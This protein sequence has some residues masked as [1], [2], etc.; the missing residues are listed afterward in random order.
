M[1]GEPFDSACRRELIYERF[2]RSVVGCTRA[3]QL[4]PKAV[5]DS[6]IDWSQLQHA[7]GAATDLP[8]LLRACTGSDLDACLAARTELRD[9]VFHQ[10]S[11]YSSTGPALRVL[12]EGLDAK[13]ADPSVACM[14]FLFDVL[15]HL[16]PAFAAGEKRAT[17]N[18]RA[19]REAIEGAVPKLQS[20]ST[21]ED[22][23]VKAWAVHLLCWMPVPVDGLAAQE[24]GRIKGDLAPVMAITSALAAASDPTLQPEC[25]AVLRTW[26]SVRPVRR[27][28]AAM[29]LPQLLGA[30][31]RNDS[32]DDELYE[33][34]LELAGGS[35]WSDWEAAPACHKGFYPDLA[36]NLLRAG[37]H[38]ASTT[39]T[40]LVPLI[41]HCENHELGPLL[42]TTLKIWFHS[43][44]YDGDAVVAMLTDL[45]RRTLMAIARTPRA[46][47]LRY[48][49]AITL[50]ELGLP[51]SANG[52]LEFLGEVA[53]APAP[54]IRIK[55]VESGVITLDTGLPLHEIAKKLSDG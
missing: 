8:P 5:P 15:E 54:D 44:P 9:R 12:F 24:L 55:S 17:S 27:K 51:L 40:V 7:Y 16:L 6:I 32:V 52:I 1:G 39:L 20:L 19:C 37:Y 43:A 34:L 29:V 35:R 31:R 21:A 30:P 4:P 42:Q 46:W 33:A 38:R 36:D 41:D 18:M 14:M 50:K 23:L 26:L 28:I 45:Q 10:G 13:R 2:V 25:V 48:R 53:N 47:E 22:V 11:I 3:Q 49:F